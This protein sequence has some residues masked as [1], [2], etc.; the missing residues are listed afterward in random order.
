MQCT[1]DINNALPDDF[2]ARTVTVSPDLIHTQT[3]SVIITSSYIFP[4]SYLPMC[5]LFYLNFSLTV[6]TSLISPRQKFDQFEKHFLCTI[7]IAGLEFFYDNQRLKVYFY[8]IFGL[9]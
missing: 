6:T 1:I 9:E 7:Q 2:I 8:M 3:L 4:T 5:L